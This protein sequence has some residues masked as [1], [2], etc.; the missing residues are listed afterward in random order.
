MTS[1]LYYPIAWLEDQ[2]SY[3]GVEDHQRACFKELG[4]V[5]VE[6]DPA[7]LLSCSNS[8]AANVLGCSWES[9]STSSKF[10]FLILRTRVSN[11]FALQ[12]ASQIHRTRSVIAWA[13]QPI[14]QTPLMC[15]K[16][17]SFFGR[18]KKFFSLVSSPLQWVLIIPELQKQRTAMPINS[19][20][21][22]SSECNS[23]NEN[24]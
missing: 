8:K 9:F 4:R 19:T 22:S 24:L 13:L 10:G 7:F 14:L 18:E 3:P 11:D 2:S 1:F 5:F 20:H 23:A 12:S 17:V 21:P 15:C 16:E 6:R